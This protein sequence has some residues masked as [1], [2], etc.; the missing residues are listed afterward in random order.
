MPAGRSGATTARAS[1]V[2]RRPLPG[3]CQ[4]V[5][6]RSVLAAQA[7]GKLP[8]GR[9]G[10]RLN[11]AAFRGGRS[12]EGHPGRHPR[13]VRRRDDAEGGDRRQCYEPAQLLAEI[14]AIN[15]E[16]DQLGI[17]LDTGPAVGLRA[18]GHA[19][20]PP[21]PPPIPAISCAF[22]NGIAALR[23]GPLPFSI[24]PD[25]CGDH[26]RDA[27]GFTGRDPANSGQG[28]APSPESVCGLARI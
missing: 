4:P 18:A 28:E 3:L 10:R 15:A 22:G 24:C 14:A 16:L 26:W 19:A 23:L 7:A 5:W 11:R 17:T 21:S 25:S 12:D 9:I 13:A 2:A 27:E 20:S 6:R 1:S 8:D